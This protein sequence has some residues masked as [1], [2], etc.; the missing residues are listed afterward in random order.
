[1]GATFSR[2]KTWVSEILTAADLN[3]EFDNILNNLDPT[4]VDDQSTNDAA[5]QA[6]R[7]PYPASA[8]SR[9]GDLAGEIQ[10]LRYQFKETL[11]GAQWYLD[12]DS[13][14]AK[15]FAGEV[16][17]AEKSNT[18]TIL[19]SDGIIYANLASSKTFTLPAV[20]G[21]DG[22]IYYISKIDATSSILTIDG[23]GSETVGGVT[24]RFLRSQND[25]IALV[26][27]ETNTDW[28]VISKSGPRQIPQ[29]KSLVVKNNTT[30]PSYQIDIDAD[31]LD[32]VN[33]GNDSIRL[34]SVN[35][36][37][38]LTG[39]GANG[40]DT[41][42]M[43]VNTTYAV[44]VIYNP[45]TNTVA[46]LLSTSFTLAG[47]TLPTNYTYGRLV[48]F[49]RTATGS[50]EHLAETNFATH[51]KWDATGDWDD[52]GGNAAYTHSAGSGNLT[53]TN[54]NLA[55]AGS[56]NTLYIFAYTVTSP[57]G[58][59]AIQITNAFALSAQT[60]SISAGAQTKMFLSAV[61]ASTADLVIA[62]TSTSGG[63]TID[64]VSLKTAS[65]IPFHSVNGIHIYDDPFDDTS[66]LASGSATSFTSVGI[67]KF[68][69]DNTLVKKV[70]LNWDADKAADSTG[71]VYFYI[72]PTGSSGNGIRLCR[73]QTETATDIA[74]TNGE[75]IMFLG[76]A[77]TFEYRQNLSAGSD[78]SIWVHG[79][80]LNL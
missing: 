61:S 28:V 60:L 36:T 3:A 17:T 40:L 34:I 31:T 25:Y 69:G 12:P 1:M 64:D 46:G 57:S 53:Q 20:S 24:S 65:I 47:L 4:G 55:N 10:G 54:A 56:N 43:A 15:L 48:D 37:A 23:N 32:V 26:C 75:V 7:D 74:H 49:C 9:P 45:V 21:N 80:Y 8:I 29:Y 38:D 73:L 70:I 6:T 42:S 58:D 76:S 33:A 51:A 30:N 14:I 5:M 22:K 27:D 50:T 62:G 35:L 68:T 13:T 78:L 41:S 52:T 63:V 39:S 19:I 59:A 11:G 77:R 44:W 18:Y 66:A 72:R 79:V 67:A 71:S 16:K 2:V